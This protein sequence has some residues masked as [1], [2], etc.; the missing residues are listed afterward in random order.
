MSALRCLVLGG[1]GAV[2]RAVCDALASR[3]VRVAFTFHT[4]EAIARDLGA[5]M[6]GS[7]ALALDLRAADE[8]A[9]VVERAVGALGW[10]DALVHCAAVAQRRR[11][12]VPFHPGV[13]DIEAADLDDLMEVNVRSAFLAVRA[14]APHLC[15]SRG[16]IVFASSVEAVRPVRSAAHYSASKCALVGLARGL[17]K[18]LGP[19]GVRVNVVAAGIMDQGV[20]SGLPP[21][22]RL[23][24]EKHA[25]LGRL[26]RPDEV[27][28]VIAH[29][30]CAPGYVTGQVLSVTGGL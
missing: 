17:S 5:T 24:Y 6:Q 10:L 19:Q 15:A 23:A 12:G 14:A 22:F 3:K 18:E 16:S 28:R 25:A 21:V 9:A 11:D 7:A 4:H 20:T 2:G 1:T 13:S 29:F 30:A 26:P 8:I 27:A